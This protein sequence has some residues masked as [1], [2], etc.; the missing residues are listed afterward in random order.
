MTLILVPVPSMLA[1]TLASAF[2]P[3]LASSLML[4]RLPLHTHTPVF[5]HTSF[6]IHMPPYRPSLI[7]LPGA[8]GDGLV[9]GGT[10]LNPL[11]LPPY[12]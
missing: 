6:A 10:H 7:P 9:G 3:T 1:P 8:P 12:L 4:I 5:S 2:T 11:P